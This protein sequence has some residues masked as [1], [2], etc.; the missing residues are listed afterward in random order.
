MINKM[1]SFIV[2]FSFFIISCDK[3]STE[4]EEGFVLPYSIGDQMLEE[5]LNTSFNIEFGSDLL[6]T[7]SLSDY[8]GKI[9]YLNLAATW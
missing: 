9:I 4:N 6:E 5:H 2:L 8:S 7:F 1:F 3:T